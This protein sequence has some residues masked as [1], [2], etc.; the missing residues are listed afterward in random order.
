MGHPDTLHAMIAA[1]DP[2]ATALTVPA[3]TYAGGAQPLRYE[4]LAAQ[5][6]HTRAQLN[7]WGL[8]RGDRVAI[9]L[10]NC[11]E[12][13]AC[14]VAV[15]SACTA[16]PLNMAYTEKDFEFYM[17]DIHARAVVIAQEGGNALAAEVARRMGIAILWLHKDT[18][19]GAGRFTLVSDLP[20]AT[21][22]QPGPAQAED[23]ALILHTS[24]T[25]SRPKIVPLLH[26][27]V[28]ASAYNIRKSLALTPADCGLHVM[29]MFHIHGLIAALL[30]PWSA[31]GRVF[32]SPGFNALK[33]F[34]WMAEGKPTWYSAVPTMHQAL[35][36]RAEKGDN[37]GIIRDNPLR[38][39]RS[40][41]SS[42]PTQV[43]A[44]LERVF[45]APLIEAYGMT[46]AAHQMCSNPLPPA[47][48]RP[49]SVGIAAGPEVAIMDDAGT[50]LGP[51][52]IGEVVIRGANV[53][54]GYENNP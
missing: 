7:G 1:Q 36:V 2:A 18:A 13:A 51:D 38:F 15:A 25:T 6:A 9:V 54:P 28:T 53:T 27:N 35:L 21:A 43:I 20:A 8:G 5:I 49:G 45:G 44:E 50:L 48:R 17:G 22:A 39:L 3:E 33:F 34:G 40:S 11:P 4:G 47:Q 23:V 42:I 32:V 37:A 41:S 24:G 10:P 12:M 52:Q 30:A 46:E 26:R 14:F 19:Q 29:P 16:A 31:G